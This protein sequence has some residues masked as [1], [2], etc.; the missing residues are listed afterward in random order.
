M[1]TEEAISILEIVAAE[2]EWD[3]S[4]EYQDALDMAIGALKKQA[5]EA[6]KERRRRMNNAEAKEKI[7][8]A[9]INCQIST[10]TAPYA[11]EEAVTTISNLIAL[12]N[13]LTK[14][15]ARKALKELIAEGLVEYKSQGCPAVISCGE[16]PELVSDAMP[17]INGYTLT[18]EGYKTEAWKQAYRDW[19]K[20]MEEWAN[21]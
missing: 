2:I 15:R 8:T 1:S 4:L 18:E 21:G 19:E 9:L 10:Y 7:F 16:V 5:L 12:I 14:Y 17:P 3:Y 13:G 11:P 20:S 6:E